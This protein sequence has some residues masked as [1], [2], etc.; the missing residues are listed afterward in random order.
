MGIK[1]DVIGFKKGNRNSISSIYYIKGSLDIG[2]GKAVVTSISCAWNSCIKK[3]ELLW[4]KKDYVNKSCM[5]W[6][7][8][9]WLNDWNIIKLATTSKNN[10]EKDRK[11]F[12]AILSGWN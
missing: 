12:G 5:Y 6:N 9:K 11:L 3:L 8:F 10:T 1:K 2:I 4:D 7:I